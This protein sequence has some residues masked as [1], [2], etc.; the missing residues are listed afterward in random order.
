MPGI[1]PQI[2]PP[3]IPASMATYQGSWNCMPTVRAKNAPTV[4]WP[5]APMLNRPVLKAKPTERPVI[6]SGA[7]V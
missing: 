7:A 1:A 6:K 2:A 3:I 4:Y 5:D